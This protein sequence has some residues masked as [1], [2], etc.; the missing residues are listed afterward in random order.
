MTDFNYSNQCSTQNQQDTAMQ[1]MRAMPAPAA[2]QSPSHLART[3]SNDQQ[4]SKAI[5]FLRRGE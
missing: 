2:T 5:I 1:A 3:V 4:M